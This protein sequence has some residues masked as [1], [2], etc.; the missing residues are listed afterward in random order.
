MDE[1][2]D[3]ISRQVVSKVCADWK[4][5]GTPNHNQCEKIVLDTLDWI[6]ELWKK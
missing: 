6:E 4:E 5:Y 3:E 2:P 1:I